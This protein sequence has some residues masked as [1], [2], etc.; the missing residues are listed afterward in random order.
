[1]AYIF[2][3]PQI[4]EL[5]MSVKIYVTGLGMVSGIGLDVPQTLDAIKNSRSGIGEL[6]LFD[7][8]HKGNLP[9]CEVKASNQKLKEDLQITKTTSRTALLGIMAAKEA[10]VSAGIVQ[11][12]VRTGLISST[13]V[14]GM[15]MSE[16][17]YGIYKKDSAKGKLRNMISHDC[18]DS[19]ERIADYLGIKDYVSTISTACSSAANAIM[20]GARLI[21]N[22][23]LDRVVVGG[24]DSLTKFTLNGFNALMI[25]DKGGC[26]P[27]DEN[28]AGLTLGEAAGYIVLESEQI[29]KKNNKKIYC[30]LKGYGNANDAYHQTASS[31]EGNGPFM[32]MKLTLDM[33]GLAIDNIDYVNVHGTGTP[34][35]D[36]SEGKA[37]IR[38]FGEKVPKFS[39]SKAYTG[40]TLGAAGGIEA[41][42]SVMCIEH[43]MI[44]PNLNFTTPITELGLIPETKFLQPVPVNNVMSNSF[45]FGGNVSSLI[46]SRV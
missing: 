5:S 9:V 26:K 27:F 6:T 12:P 46:F 39:S 10:L 11:S 21:K 40:H 8:V 34:N 31:P 20:F 18:G 28:R 19:T 41:V 35:N 24:T 25:V 16:K 7:S 15:D 4:I 36:L 38:L 29:V 44:I 22:G 13:S 30:E 43:Q 33:S 45:G 1:V 2:L 17:F 23:F 3:V 42:L 37:L 14:G 32:S